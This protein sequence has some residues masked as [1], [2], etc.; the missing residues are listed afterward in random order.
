MKILLEM[1]NQTIGALRAELARRTDQRDQWHRM[2]N[3]LDAAIN[4]HARDKG[5]Y[6]DGDDEALYAA[7]ERVYE[8]CAEFGKRN[9]DT[10]W[11]SP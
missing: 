3:A 4:H 5:T 8:R 11:R 9:R 1:A 10:A 6:G 2:F 7:R